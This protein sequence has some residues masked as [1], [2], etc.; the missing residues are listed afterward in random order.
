MKI[1]EFFINFSHDHHHHHSNHRHQNGGHQ[2]S[3]A[4]ASA[5]SAASRMSATMAA[6]HSAAAAQVA[7]HQA[8]AHAASRD[9]EA[10]HTVGQSANYKSNV[11][12]NRDVV[13]VHHRSRSSSKAN[14]HNDVEAAMAAAASAVVGHSA[15]VGAGPQGTCQDGGCMDCGIHP[16]LLRSSSSKRRPRQPPT[17]SHSKIFLHF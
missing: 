2:S 16:S 5:H 7:A 8:A 1:K 6:A 4:A 17:N 15:G 3:G 13:H 9:R 11:S 12:V 14:L 10:G